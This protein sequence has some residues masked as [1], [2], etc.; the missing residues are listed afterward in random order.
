MGAKDTR[1]MQSDFA[2]Q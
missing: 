2:V 1:N